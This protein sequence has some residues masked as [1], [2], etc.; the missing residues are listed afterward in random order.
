MSV[1]SLDESHFQKMV[2]SLCLTLL[3]IWSSLSTVL[4]K[5]GLVYV[6]NVGEV[7]SSDVTVGEFYVSVF[8]QDQLQFLR[9]G[10]SGDVSMTRRMLLLFLLRSGIETNPGPPKKKEILQRAQEMR[11][12]WAFL[13]QQRLLLF[14][15][16]HGKSLSW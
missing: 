13:W 4:E 9:I 2:Y 6:N 5:D 15:I 3:M 16:I 11:N 7:F 12:V 14:P 8:L 10:T 1:Q